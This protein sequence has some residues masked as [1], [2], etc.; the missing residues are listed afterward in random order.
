[1]VEQG[2]D[3]EIELRKEPYRIKVGNDVFEFEPE[4]VTDRY[5]D[6]YSGVHKVQ[7]ETRAA[8]AEGGE[9][10]T[11]EVL[12]RITAANREFLAKLML[13]ESAAT[14]KETKLPERVIGLMA[15]KIMAH[16]G[17]DDR[18]TGPSSASPRGSSASGAR[19]TGRSR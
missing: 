6:A 17:G 16:Y 11:P 5:L 10:M 18:P 1:M 14:F 12:E 15:Q 9:G 8:R 4:M 3:E 19:S 7:Q 13:D 2:W